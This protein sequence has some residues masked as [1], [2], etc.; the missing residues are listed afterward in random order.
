MNTPELLWVPP[1]TYQ[2]ILDQ[3]LTVVWL[4]RAEYPWPF[5]PDTVM[6]LKEWDATRVPDPVPPGMTRPAARRQGLTGRQCAVH[7]LAVLDDPRFV[8]PEIVGL[9]VR[10]SETPNG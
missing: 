5:V 6:T 2:H 3:A 7:V 8:R 1:E 4:S 10:R 9:L